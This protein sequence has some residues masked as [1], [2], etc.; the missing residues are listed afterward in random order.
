VCFDAIIT[1]PGEPRSQERHRDGKY[2]N[3]YDPSVG[4]KESLTV[5][6]LAQW[7]PDGFPTDNRFEIDVSFYSG[8]N[9]K[10]GDNCYKCITDAL[11]GFYWKND[12]QIKDH[13]VHVIDNSDNPRTVLMIKVVEEI[14]K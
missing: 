4:A 12:K 13:H 10:D 11:E 6:C 5:Q 9:V 1:I 3:K 7:R 14:K 2:G 8:K